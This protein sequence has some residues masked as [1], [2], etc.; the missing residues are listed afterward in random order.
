MSGNA[1]M[2]SQSHPQSGA[3]S[4]TPRAPSDPTPAQDN[5]V[6]DGQDNF[7]GYGGLGG[8]GIDTQVSRQTALHGY[9]GLGGLGTDTQ[10]SGQIANHA[11]RS[12][13]SVGGYKELAWAP[14]SP[15]S[16]DTYDGPIS[17]LL[18]PKNSWEH[19]IYVAESISRLNSFVHGNSLRSGSQNLHSALRERDEVVPYPIFIACGEGICFWLIPAG[20][21]DSDASRLIAHSMRIYEERWDVCGTGAG[22][23]EGAVLVCGKLTS[24]ELQLLNAG[25]YP[26]SLYLIGSPAGHSNWLMPPYPLSFNFPQQRAIF[27]RRGRYPLSEAV[28]TQL[29]A[30]GGVGGI[31]R[32]QMGPSQEPGRQIPELWSRT[33]DEEVASALPYGWLA[34]RTGPYVYYV[35]NNSRTTTWRR[36]RAN[37]TQTQHA[38][39]SQKFGHTISG[40]GTQTKQEDSQRSSVVG[41]YGADT[42][43]TGWQRGGADAMGWWDYEHTMKIERQCQNGR[44]P[45]EIEGSSQGP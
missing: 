24:E 31:N 2:N 19:H 29:Q 35:D 30:P 32:P 16:F 4:L 10:G 41:A 21:A 13:G 34:R 45:S 6:R 23:H 22:A 25:Y 3:Q 9:G 39:P 37:E 5:S 42:F 15:V 18:L 40:V 26:L 8:L 43:A 20:K 7:H 33:F 1:T 11:G 27:Q 12:P 28:S 14:P 44:E 17:A 38:G 36:P